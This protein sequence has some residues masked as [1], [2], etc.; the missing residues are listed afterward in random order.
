MINK[1]TKG[2]KIFNVVNICLLCLLLFITFFP[3]WYVFVGSFNTGTDFTKGGVYFFPRE[4]TL[5]NYIMAFKNDDIFNALTISVLRTVIG[6]VVSLF[7]T[8]FAAYAL[9]C[10]TLPGRN[11]FSFFF[12]FS[13]IFSGGMIPYFLLL[14]DL[15]LTKSFWIFIIPTIFS[16]FN[17]ILLR[18]NFSTVPIELKESALLDGASEMKILTRIYIP[19]SDPILATLALFIGVGH[20]ND[21]FTAAYYVSDVNLYPA[22]TLLQKILTESTDSATIMGQEAISGGNEKFT[23]QSLQFAFVM[24]LTIP[25]VMVYPFLQKYYVKGIMVGS[26]KG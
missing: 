26:V 20:W 16:F 7:F 2:E 12:F 24:I 10:K 25:I 6:V 9:A 19:L 1:R 18:T 13:G 23:P 11:I 3:F 8:S 21:W 14:R 4:F 17:M 5:E 22:A 15:G